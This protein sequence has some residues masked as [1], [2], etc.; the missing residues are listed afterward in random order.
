MTTTLI[1]ARLNNEVTNLLNQIAKKNNKSKSKIIEEAIRN[2]NE[3]EIKK[4]IISSY[5][6]LWKDKESLELTEIWTSDFLATYN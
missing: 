3:N 1:S 6:N 2:Y 4:S 5:K